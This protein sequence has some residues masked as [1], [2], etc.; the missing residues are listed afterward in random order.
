MRAAVFTSSSEPLAIR[1]IE[2]PRPG[3]G[4]VGLQVARVGIAHRARGGMDKNRNCRQHSGQDEASG[5][6]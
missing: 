5:H 3:T 4:E 2:R 1:E 6:E